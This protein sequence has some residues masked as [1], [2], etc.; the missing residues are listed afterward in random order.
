M[1]TFKNWWNSLSRLQTYILGGS[2]GIIT[3]SILYLK[4]VPTDKTY[5]L[6]CISCIVGVLF[7]YLIYNSV[8][9]YKDAKK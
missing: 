5:Y 8:V 7:V 3:Y 6:V 2:L 1:T 9:H 4:G